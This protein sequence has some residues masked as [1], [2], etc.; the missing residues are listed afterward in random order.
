MLRN[1][2]LFPAVVCLFAFALLASH[3]AKADDT[4][5]SQPTGSITVT[6]LDSDGKPVVKAR[7]QLFPKRKIAE[8][9]DATPSPKPKAIAKGPTDEDGKFTF[10]SVA[11]GDYKV[12]AS[13]KKTHAKGSATVSVTADSQSPAIT[14][15]LSS[16]D[17]TGGATTM[18]STVPSP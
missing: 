2:C 13:F 14:I 18:P 10:D 16:P 11:V 15:N 9:D 6:V 8:G 7:V 3:N 1:I 5:T 17:D 4:A 12:N